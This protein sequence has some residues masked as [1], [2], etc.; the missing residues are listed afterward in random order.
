MKNLKIIIL[1]LSVYNYGNASELLFKKF[2]PSIALIHNQESKG[3]GLIISTDGLVL[4]NYHVV[5]S[6]LPYSITVKY[7]ENGQVR[8]NTFDNIKLFKVHPELDLAIL[9]INSNKRF[10]PAQIR[11]VNA[12]NG[13]KCYAIGNPGFDKTVL[14]NTITEG[15]ISSSERLIDK[16]NYIQFS[17]AVNPG[18]S[19]G[20]LVNENGDVIGIVTYKSNNTKNVNFAIP[21]TSIKLSDFLNLAER[22]DNLEKGLEY[23]KKGRELIEKYRLTS[24]YFYELKS[25]YKYSALY[26]F[27][28]SLIEMPNQS[29]AY[30]NVGLMFQEY[31][32]ID[33]AKIYFLRA[34]KSKSP[35][36]LN[37]NALASLSQIQGDFESQKK[38]LIKGSFLLGTEGWNSCTYDLANNFYS[39]QAFYSCFYLLKMLEF[40]EQQKNK[41]EVDRLIKKII[42]LIRDYKNV[43]PHIYVVQIKDME[44]RDTIKAE[45]LEKGIEVGFHYQPNHLLSFYKNENISLPV[46]EKVYKELLTLP[47]HVD[48]SQDDISH[49]ASSL[50]QLL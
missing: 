29:S 2:E 32:L 23:Q 30:H 33:I 18:N 45:L 42:P 49:I 39:D 27:R 28:L 12:K 16:Y 11:A 10:I 37:Y 34:T 48:L 47:L 4:T 15:L 40:D 6:I 7:N 43:V 21:V 19:G 31:G 24:P 20:P 3:T 26:F 35:T 13:E 8:S 25:L 50:K 38:Y 9:K 41:G 36:S 14:Q 1:F 22:K 5:N 46:T 44:D 17:A